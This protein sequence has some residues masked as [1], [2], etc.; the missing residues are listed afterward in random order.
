MEKASTEREDGP[1][2]PIMNNPAMDRR[3]MALKEVEEADWL[4]NKIIMEW[5][6]RDRNKM[7]VC[8]RSFDCRNYEELVFSTSRGILKFRFCV[9]SCGELR[10]RDIETRE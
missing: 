1:N 9:S 3:I 2:A 5:M 6:V 10:N 7:T 8:L 4:E